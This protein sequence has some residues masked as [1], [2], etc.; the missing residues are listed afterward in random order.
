MNQ[1]VKTI[2]R[3]AVF[4]ISG[5][6]PR[7]A[8]HYHTLYKEESAKQTAINGMKLEVGPRQKLQEHIHHWT[9]N[10]EE[11]HTDY[12]VLGWDDLVRNHWISK[13]LTLAWRSL[14]AY[15]HVIVTGAL[16]RAGQVNMAPMLTYLYPLALMLLLALVSYITGGIVAG[17]LPAPFAILTWLL[18][19]GIAAGCFAVGMRLMEKL[20]VYW[21]LRIFCFGSGQAKAH[22]SESVERTDYFADF[23]ATKLHTES[24]DEILL[25]GHSVGTILLPMMGEK[26][27]TD[28]P[29]LLEKPITFI[30]LGQCVPLVSFMPESEPCRK[31]LRFMARQPLQWLDL[32]APPDGVSFSLTGPFKEICEP[33]ALKLRCASP[34]FHSL[35]DMST[36]NRI[37]RNKFRMH[38]QYLMAGDKA[39]KYDYFL[40]TAGDQ[41]LVLKD[42][43]RL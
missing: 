1:S 10:S 11:T 24:Y 27:L 5:F 26:L 40:L 42:D 39:G 3:R 38:F 23:I 19:I 4:Y 34:R 29:D 32:A 22:L 36:Y 33:G 7:G 43:V 2:R 37:K 9:V 25:I 16:W 15:W 41:P 8:R 12:H 21:L 30:T 31:A 18:K 17:L 20:H 35:L 6:D 13:P 28:H 14:Q